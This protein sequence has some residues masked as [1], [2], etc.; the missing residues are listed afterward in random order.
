MYIQLAEQQKH[1]V[2]VFDHLLWAEDEGIKA[3][4]FSVHRAVRVRHLG[5]WNRARTGGAHQPIRTRGRRQD[6]VRR[7][8]K[9]C[10]VTETTDHIDIPRPTCVRRSTVQGPAANRGKP[11]NRR[12]FDS[13]HIPT[14]IVVTLASRTK[15]PQLQNKVFAMRSFRQ[16]CWNASV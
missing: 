14:G 10:L 7:S 11:P 5:K 3:R 13:T 8:R 2:E 6:V 15:S 4:R 1:P 12:F 16:N 9:C